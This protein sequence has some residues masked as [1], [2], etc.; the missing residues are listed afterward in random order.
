MRIIVSEN[1]YKTI[2]EQMKIQYA[3]EKIDEFVQEGMRYI[4]NLKQLYEKF[5]ND[6]M[7]VSVGDVF[8]DPTELKSKLDILNK[9][10]ER[11]EAVSNKYYGAIEMY[12]VGEYPDNVRK[13]DEIYSDIDSMQF[14]IDEISDIYQAVYDSVTHFIEWNQSKIKSAENRDNF[15]KNFSFYK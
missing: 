5:Y 7:T 13:L 1:Q 15:T 14:D 2:L 11:T 6:I 12:E 10:K 3:P 4:T 9:S 8:Q